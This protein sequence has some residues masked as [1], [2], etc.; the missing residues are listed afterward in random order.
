[1]RILLCTDGWPHG[2]AALRFGALL[3]QGSPDPA[4]LLGVVE[5]AQDQARVE[6]ALQEGKEWLAGAPT[7]QTKLRRGHADEEI[8]D[9]ASPEAYDLVVVGTRGRRG[10]TRFLLGSTA[11]RIARH[12]SL[13]VL[14]VQGQ[15]EAVKRI[16]IC[17]AGGEPGLAAVDLA[18]RVAQ[19]VGAQVT[20]LHV[21]SQ[22]PALPVV[23]HAGLFGVMPQTPV[24]PEVPDVLLKDLEAPAEELMDHDTPE[25]AHLRQALAML[26]DLGVPARARVRHGL[27]IDEIEDEACEGDY[28]LVVVGSRSAEGWMRFLLNDLGK[29]ILSCVGRPMLAAK[30]WLRDQAP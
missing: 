6:Q 23:P 24:P 28:D 8:L 19:L 4:T 12:A 17:T 20:V 2:Q 25:G 21:M 15:R 5:H 7:P 1:M 18:G 27:V 22:L 29:Q 3:A 10:L 16:L 26:A 13:P 30:T 11:E 14:L 9:E